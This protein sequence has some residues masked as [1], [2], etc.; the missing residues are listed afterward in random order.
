MIRSARPPFFFRFFDPSHL[1]CRMPGAEKRIFLTFDDGP[2]PEVTPEVLR[3]LSGY[4]AKATFFMVGDNIR[5]NPA[6]FEQVVAGGHAIGNHTFHHLNGWKTAPAAYAEDVMRFRQYDA[7]KLFRPPYGRFTPSQYMI[8]KKEFLFVM[9]SLLT[10]DFSK[11]VTPEQCLS[12]AVANTRP[13][14]IVVFHD[15]L[16]ASK[17]VLFTLPGYLEHF[18]RLGYSFESV[19]G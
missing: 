10:W 3:I 2:V 14:E 8:L 15:S 16:K 13:G 4:N 12:A 7:T 6:L 11:K 19:L 17:N 1:V 9:W 5:K 18:A